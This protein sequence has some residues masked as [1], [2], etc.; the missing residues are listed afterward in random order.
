VRVFAVLA[1]AASLAASACSS[2]GAGTGRFGADAERG[3]LRVGLERP[4]SLDPAQA[5][6]VADFLVVDQLFDGLTAYDPATLEVRPSL[7]SRWEVSPNQR[8]WTFH[9]RTDATFSN[10]RAITS[11]DVKYTLD[12]IA[13]RGS[14]S[15]AAP[16]LDAVI[17]FKEVNSEGTLDHMVGVITPDPATVQIALVHP[18]SVLA[19][20][21]ASPAFGIVPR[22]AVEAAPPAPA[23]AEQPV[24]SGPFMFRSRNVD[25]LRLMPSPGADVELRGIDVYF[26]S[27]GEEAYAAFLR[28]QLDWT[29][30]P[31]ERVEQVVRDRG[32]DSFRPYPAQLFYGFNLDNPKF[33]DV[34]FREAIVRAVDRQAIVDNVYGGRVRLATGVVAAGV[35]GHQPDPCGERCRYD[36]ARA[37][38]L[39]AE[40]F[41]NRPVPT[42]NIDFDDDPTQEAVARS[43]A[44]GLEAVGIP[45]GLRPHAYTEYLKF[46]ASGQQELF[47]MAW[48]APY[49]SPDAFL[50]PLFYSGKDD[51]IVSFNSPDVDA[52]IRAGRETGDRAAAMAA[53]QAAEQL[54]MAHMVVLP[55]AQYETHT[56]VADRVRDLPMSAFGT[57]DA[58][59]ARL[60]G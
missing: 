23:F 1:V 47:Q 33:S 52:F 55:I 45:A 50:A 9:L 22:E 25:V 20:I 59:R 35:P 46:A 13:A 6:Y 32:R 40:V 36:P 14:G 39:V 11:E 34:R 53:Y 17:G 51:N 42:V 2:S 15:P 16:Q 28:G 19:E 7:A 44:A 21:L 24:G 43:M 3:V 38:A 41:G 8:I 5:R 30:V 4:Q 48:I 37:R 26:G 56:L 27:D 12:R 54:V 18:L 49:A 29:A 10:G 31:A 60:S 57:F 58:S